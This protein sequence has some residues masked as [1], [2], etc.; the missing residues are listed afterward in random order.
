M[1]DEDGV[2]GVGLGST[3]S[4]SSGHC[5]ACPNGSRG[6]DDSALCSAF[7]LRPARLVL[8]QLLLLPITFTDRRCTLHG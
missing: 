2:N 8:Q 1:R 3:S 6:V 5:H 7:K 4:V